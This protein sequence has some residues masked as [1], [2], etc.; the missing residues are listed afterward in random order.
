MGLA[1]VPPIKEAQFRFGAGGIYSAEAPDLLKDGQYRY[2][3]NVDTN[4]EG[5]LCSRNGVLQLGFAGTPFVPTC[6]YIKKL[7]AVPGEGPLAPITNPR[8]CGIVSSG[9]RDIYRTT[10]YTAFTLVATGVDNTPTPHWEMSAYSAGDTGAAWAYFACPNKMVKDSFFNAF[11]T[12]PSWGIPPASGSAMAV[13]NGAGNLNGGASTSPNNSQPYDWIFTWEETTTSDEGNPSQPMLTA[14]TY[15]FATGGHTYGCAP[16]ALLNQQANVLAWGTGLSNIGFIK[17][18]RRGGI[19]TDGIYRLVATVANPGN[20]AAVTVTDNTADADLV[21][22][23]QATFDNDPPVTSTVPQPLRA[24]TSGITAG[25]AV[26]TLSS[27]AFA[28]VKQGTLAYIN[29]PV[30]AEQVVVEVATANTIRAFFQFAHASGTQMEID[31]ITGQPCNLTCSISDSVLVAG[32]P[33]NPAALYKSKTGAPQAFPVGTDASG[34]ITTIN[35][36]TPANGIVNMCE[37]RGQVLCLNYSSLFEVAVLSGSLLAPAEV[38]K[39][40]LMTQ[41]AWCKTETEVWFLSDDGIY[42]WDGGTLRWRSEVIDTIFHNESYNGIPPIN[43]NP[44]PLATARMEYRRGRVRLLYTDVTGTIQQLSCNVR[45]QNSWILFQEQLGPAN[46]AITDIYREED[47]GSLIVTATNALVGAAFGIADTDLINTGANQFTTPNVNYTSDWWHG[48]PDSGGIPISWDVRL[49]WFDGGQPDIVKQWEEL[50]LD[51]DP[52]IYNG[53]FDNNSEITVELLLDYQDTPVDTFVF[54]VGTGG[55]L[56]GRQL[57]SLLPLLSGGGGAGQPAGMF[58]SYGREGRAISLH[59]Y[60]SA[61]PI[62]ATLY[63]LVVRYEVTGPLT[64]GASS[65]WNDLGVKT[66]KRVYQMAVE[67][68]TAGVNQQVILDI[69]GGRDGTTLKTPQTFTLSNPVMTGPNRC[70]KVFPLADLTVGKLFRVRAVSDAQGGQQSTAFFRILSVTFPMSENYPE[71]VVNFTEWE[72]GGYKYDKYLNQVDLEVNTN[73]VAVMVQMQADGVSQGPAFPV[74]ATDAARRVNITMPTGLVG[75]QW[76]IFVDITQAAIA[77]GAGM[78][79][80]FKH[81][82]GMQKADPGEVM[83]TFDWDDLGYQ[84][85]KNFR[86]VSIEWDDTGGMNVTLQMDTLSGING[87]II[88]PNVTQFAVT[89]GRSQK[90][91]PI[92]VDTI[93]KKIRIY[94]LGNPSVTFKMWKYRFVEG[95]DYDLYPADVAPSTPW[96]DASSPDNKNPTWLWIDADTQN[97]VASV[98]LQN[99]NGTA[100]TVAHTGTVT[101]RKKNY[102]IPPDIFAKMWRMLSTPGTGGKMQL[103]SW[104]FQRWH[105]WDDGAPDDP[106][107]IALWTPWTDFGYAY[108]KL[109]RNLIL[110]INTNNAPCSVALQTAENGTVQV[111]NVNQNYTDRRAILACNPNLSGTQW[112][113]LLTPAS[114]GI[115]QL[116]SW[117]LDNVKL[118]PAVSQ[119]YSYGQ[120]FGYGFWKFVK[121]ISLDYQCN[122]PITFALTSDTGSITLTF[123]AHPI[124]AVERQYLPTVWGAG[125]NKSRLYS[126]AIVSTVAANPFMVFADCSV[127]EWIGL[128]TDRHAAY[129]QFKLSEFQQIAI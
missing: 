16:L 124:R 23:P 50:L 91:F 109:A 56:F 53:G 128:G 26:A 115:A 57:I 47:T 18:Y 103:F 127:I 20:E 111:F 106:P 92:P 104:S 110:T 105:P 46:N 90:V 58:T 80:L 70:L 6:Y 121:Q 48:N 93:C 41:S 87:N 85:D 78:F 100:L 126:T 68:D 45:K 9:V 79:Q 52:Q 62:P 37:F 11:A 101:N 82:L 22:Q 76:R 107:E 102:A 77:T 43:M 31:A 74:Q 30:N 19:L 81:Y 21:Y 60:G 97:V 40:G 113:L 51:I 73:N 42:S 66:D 24:T 14:S 88:T 38:A 32:D 122:S 33:N 44:G 125:L 67:F 65:A 71:D 64:S 25:W 94:P 86:S 112:R 123:P 63:R 49:P 8:Y 28:K 75:K 99:E 69:L 96:Q 34:A 119:W 54:T 36:G 61:Y 7:C 10:N 29:D 55:S 117:Q 84:W 5:A 95:K 3:E 83:H 72:D 120:S 17:I 1:L 89:G 35:V 59:I 108:G 114:N 98:V 129:Q 27:S 2:A 118:P 13:A 15:T 39:K 116:W 12:L 4:Q